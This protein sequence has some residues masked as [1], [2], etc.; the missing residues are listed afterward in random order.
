MSIREWYESECDDCGCYHADFVILCKECYEKRIKINIKK[1]D[2]N[3][4]HN[5]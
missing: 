3:K 4:K 1:D 5:N 2:T